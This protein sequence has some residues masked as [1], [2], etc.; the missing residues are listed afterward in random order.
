MSRIKQGGAKGT[1]FTLT[2][3][4]S[5][6]LATTIDGYDDKKDAIDKLVTLAADYVVSLAGDNAVPN[7]KIIGI[8]GNSTSGYV[9]TV[10]IFTLLCQNTNVSYFSPQCVISMPYD[11][12][13][14][15]GD[16]VQTNGTDGVDVDDAGTSAGNGFV[17]A[18][19][20]PSGYIDVAF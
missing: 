13:I 17:L 6:A 16:T 9:L 7:G 15:F 10:H 19:D 12:T 14:A 2:C 11:G 5:S 3:T 1:V 8:T 4:P 20:N 18:K